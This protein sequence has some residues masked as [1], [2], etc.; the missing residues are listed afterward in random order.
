M[1]NRALAATEV[2]RDMEVPVSM[3]SGLLLNWMFESGETQVMNANWG[4]AIIGQR[5]RARM[6]DLS[7]VVNPGWVIRKRSS[8]PTA[9]V[10]GMSRHSHL[11]SIHHQSHVDSN[12]HR[13][14]SCTKSLRYAAQLS[15]I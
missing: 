2:R 9:W 13:E 12:D 14:T 4:G 8:N 15:V 10:V 11:C 3:D 1:W 5:P 6:S 7:K